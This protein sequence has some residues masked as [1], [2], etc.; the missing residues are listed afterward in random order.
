M[1]MEVGESIA[2]TTLGSSDVCGEPSGINGQY[3][4]QCIYE[5]MYRFTADIIVRRSTRQVESSD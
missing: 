4:C 1:Y 3:L 5:Q 2:C